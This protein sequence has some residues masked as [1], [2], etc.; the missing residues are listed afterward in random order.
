MIQGYIQPSIHQTLEQQTEARQEREKLLNVEVQAEKEIAEVLPPRW[1][2]LI[3]SWR[4]WKMRVIETSQHY[5]N[6]YGIL[7]LSSNGLG[8]EEKS[9]VMN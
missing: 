2:S 7:K 9:Q 5:K 8:I 4:G 3:N 6:V 1:M